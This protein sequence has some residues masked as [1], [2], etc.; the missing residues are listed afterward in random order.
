MRVGHHTVQNC[1]VY[2]TPDPLRAQHVHA[3]NSPYPTCWFPLWP[4]PPVDSGVCSSP[5]HPPQV[6]ADKYGNVVHLGERDCSVQ[7]RNQKLVE[8]APSPALTPEVGMRETGGGWVGGGAENALRAASVQPDSRVVPE[9]WCTRLCVWRLP[10]F[11]V[12]CMMGSSRLPWPRACWV[13]GVTGRGFPCGP[14]LGLVVTRGNRRVKGWTG[15]HPR[16]QGRAT[17]W[18]P[19]V[20]RIR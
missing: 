19:S 20:W 12:P 14:G 1:R 10:G 5:H 9:Q 8:E 16:G 17:G 6:L 13:W 2:V 15:N 4:P 3:L 11:G 18:M 7:R